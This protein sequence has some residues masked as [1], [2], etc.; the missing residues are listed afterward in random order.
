MDAAKNKKN[1]REMVMQGKLWVA[2]YH[3]FDMLFQVCMFEHNNNVNVS[4]VIYIPCYFFIF[5]QLSAVELT[6]MKFKN[7]Y[8]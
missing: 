7:F 8:M 3:N 4:I 1:K 5:V 2:L 6:Y